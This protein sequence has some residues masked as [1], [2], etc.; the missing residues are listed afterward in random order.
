MNIFFFFS[1]VG[2]LSSQP[3][4]E[5]IESEERKREQDSSGVRKRERERETNEREMRERERVCVNQTTDRMLHRIIIEKKR[6]N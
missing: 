1:F 3:Q 2:C 5:F 6:R 4:S